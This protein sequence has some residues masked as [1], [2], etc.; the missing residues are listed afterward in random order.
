MFLELFIILFTIVLFIGIILYA[1]N[2][3]MVTL[4]LILGFAVLFSFGPSV[5]KLDNHFG[6]YSSAQLHEI[7]MKNIKNCNQLLAY[8]SNIA[9]HSIQD[10]H[11]NCRSEFIRFYDQHGKG[12]ISIQWEKFKLEK[13]K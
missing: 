6:Y 13:A 3:T 5:I 11:I 9:I 10:L 4:F 2:L 12:D 1:K 7:K 8:N